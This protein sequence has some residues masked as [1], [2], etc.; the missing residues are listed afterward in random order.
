MCTLVNLNQVL[1]QQLLLFFINHP[2]AVIH[3]QPTSLE[4]GGRWAVMVLNDPQLD[5]GH[6]S[7]TPL[8]KALLAYP[9]KPQ[10]S[11][12]AQL[13]YGDGRVYRQ[14]AKKYVRWRPTLTQLRL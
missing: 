10:A 1:F 5:Y 4:D 12:H 3:L 14:D 2:K 11:F 13:F 8:E 7:G 6:L 9:T